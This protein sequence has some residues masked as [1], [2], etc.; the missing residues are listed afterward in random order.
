MSPRHYLV[1]LVLVSILIRCT[2]SVTHVFV[3]IPHSALMPGN[4]ALG[5]ASPAPSAVLVLRALQLVVPWVHPAALRALR[6][7]PFGTLKECDPVQQTKLLAR[8]PDLPCDL[9]LDKH[10]NLALLPIGASSPSMSLFATGFAPLPL[11]LSAI[12]PDVSMLLT[13]ET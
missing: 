2:P 6:R 11:R 9:P 12:L 10:L 7:G 3:F 5:P 13:I 1:P 8:V 4:K